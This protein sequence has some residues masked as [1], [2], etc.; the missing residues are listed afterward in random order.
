MN[1][2]LT[3]L[4]IATAL[5]APIRAEEGQPTPEQL[6]ALKRVMKT[7]GELSYQS[8]DIPLVDGKAQIKFTDDFRFLD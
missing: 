3:A 5:V 2:I 1:T 6:N 7:I 4:V 8:G